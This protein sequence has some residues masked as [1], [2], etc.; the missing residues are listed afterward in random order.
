[1]DDATIAAAWIVGRLL[2]LIAIGLAV[3]LLNQAWPDR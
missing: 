3:Y 2:L 1:M